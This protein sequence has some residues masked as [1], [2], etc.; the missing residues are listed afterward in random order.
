M[1]NLQLQVKAKEAFEFI[2][3]HPALDNPA[4]PACFP[5]NA[6]WFYMAPCCK[7]GISDSSKT[8]ISIWRGQKGW[9]KFKDQFDKEHKDDPTCPKTLQRIYVPYK[10][11]YGEPW[12]FDHMEYWYEIT[13]YAFHGDP[14]LDDAKEWADPVKWQGYRGPEGGAN[15]FDEMLID[16]A[17]K[18]KKELGDFNSYY[19][20]HTQ[21]ELKNHRKHSPFNFKKLKGNKKGLSTMDRNSDYL[22]VSPGEIN[23]RWLRWYAKTPM[24]KKDWGKQFNGLIAKLTRG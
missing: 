9:E 13:F 24:C 14:Y 2:N 4:G 17:K 11:F 8:K 3:S 16:C 19:D 20:M 1:T 6:M 10:D 22:S 21:K 5:C 7:R 18:V 12:K 15:T 23:L